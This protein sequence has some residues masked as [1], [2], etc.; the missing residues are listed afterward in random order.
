MWFTQYL[1]S[2]KYPKE[3]QTCILAHWVGRDGQIIDAAA[4]DL[5]SCGRIEYFFSQRLLLTNGQYTETRMTCVKWF[6]QHDLRHVLMTPAQLWHENSFK[7]FG[8]ASF[9][10][11]EKVLEICVSRFRNG[12]CCKFFEKKNVSIKILLLHEICNQL[13]FVCLS[14]HVLD[15]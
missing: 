14:V 8:P 12:N 3:V 1:K 4:G 5:S 10:P 11:M 9:I 2:S 13:C 6:Q 15:N 7:A